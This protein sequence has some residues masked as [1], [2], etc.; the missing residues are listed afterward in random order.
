MAKR[1]TTIIIEEEIGLENTKSVFV[2]E[3]NAKEVKTTKT[4]KSTSKNKSKTAKTKTKSTTSKSKTNTSKSKSTSKKDT[5]KKTTS[6]KSSKKSSRTKEKEVKEIVSPKDIETKD[7][8]EST[9]SSIIELPSPNQKENTK[10][11]KNK[12]VIKEEDKLTPSLLNNDNKEKK[13]L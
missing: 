6:K 7:H 3:E 11:L 9:Q 13:K 10:D 5:K 2:N 1:R 8:L 12:I 4:K